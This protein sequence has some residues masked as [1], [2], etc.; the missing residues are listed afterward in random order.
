MS[1]DIA[2]IVNQ[3]TVFLG[4]VVILALIVWI[5]QSIFYLRA[6]LHAETRL[7]KELSVLAEKDEQVRSILVK[8]DAEIATE[9]IKSEAY[10][11]ACDV[12]SQAARSLKAAERDAVF[13][14]IQRSMPYL[15]KIIR[16][17]LGVAA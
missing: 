7:E 10:I 5:V 12:L 3:V 1:S 13:D 15:S 16:K 6:K 14:G 4:A 2:I 9:G 8:L 11:K 17:S